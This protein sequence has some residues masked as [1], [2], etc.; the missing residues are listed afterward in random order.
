MYKDLCGEIT[1][2]KNGPFSL[3]KCMKLEVVLL[4]YATQKCKYNY[5]RAYDYGDGIVEVI[6]YH[7]LTTS[8][9]EPPEEDDDGLPWPEGRARVNDC[10]L[11][12]NVKRAGRR[13]RELVLCNP[14]GWFFTFTVDEKKNHDRYNL[15][16]VYKKIAQF[17]RNYNSK[18]GLDLKFL[19][20]PEKHKDGAWHFHGFIM[21]LPKSHLTRFSK[22]HTGSS[23]INKKVK[24]GEEIYDW[25]P[26]AKKFGYCDLEPIKDK[27]RASSYIRKYI[28]KDLG[29]SVTE[30]GKHLF[31]CSQGLKGR[32]LM[33]QGYWSG[34][35]VEHSFRNGYAN[36][37]ATKLCF[38]TT[39]EDGRKLRDSYF[40]RIRPEHE[41]Q[42]CA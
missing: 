22:E 39:T 28:M 37:F 36:E 10:K 9:L 40:E 26:Y 6:L 20:V 13:I 34:T 31:R 4:P 41:E 5:V 24:D 27:A 30:A 32:V 16:E 2:R 25:E 42:P 35:D 3:K 11:E 33:K 12:E 29:R 23:Y 1:S 18:H 19:I 8:G 7:A 38:D 21:G 14:W 17:F 15:E